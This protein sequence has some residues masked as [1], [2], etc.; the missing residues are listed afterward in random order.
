VEAPPLS[1][2]PSPPPPAGSDLKVLEALVGGRVVQAGSR[3]AA[4][5]S[6]WLTF[7]T[8]G[9]PWPQLPSSEPARLTLVVEGLHEFA[10]PAATMFPTDAPRCQFVVRGAAGQQ[11]CCSR[12]LS[13][14]WQ[15]DTCGCRCGATVASHHLARLTVTHTWQAAQS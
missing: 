9:L 12:G 4:A 8:L 1:S 3:R 13:R 11:Q 10:C 6:S 2:A 7:S 15:G 5:G 14:Q